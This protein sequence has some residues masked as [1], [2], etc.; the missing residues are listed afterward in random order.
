MEVKTI[1]IREDNYKSPTRSIR[2]NRST[3][4]CS[5]IFHKAR[6]KHDT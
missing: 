4:K 5:K 1:Q 3:E 2:L 6:Q